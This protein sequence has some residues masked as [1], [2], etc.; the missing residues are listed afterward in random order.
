MWK[1]SPYLLRQIE[2]IGPQMSKNLAK[3]GITNF[4]QIREVDP[5]RIEMVSISSGKYET[6]HDALKIISLTLDIASRAAVW[7]PG[8]V[9]PHCP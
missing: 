5:G 1:S 9:S 4:D 2:R 3:A 6:E 7:E 8:K